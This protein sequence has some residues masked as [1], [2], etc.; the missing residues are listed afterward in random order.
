MVGEAIIWHRPII[1]IANLIESLLANPLDFARY[2]SLLHGR[3]RLQIAYS[4]SNMCEESEYLKVATTRLLIDALEADAIK[5]A[6]RIWR[7]LREP[8]VG[9]SSRNR[10][11]G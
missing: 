6:P 11:A 1:H 7:P 10:S 4:D 9:A 5:M 3:Q 2:K 8:S